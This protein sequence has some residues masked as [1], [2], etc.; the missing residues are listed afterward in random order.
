[1]HKLNCSCK[2][3]PKLQP[4]IVVI[5]HGEQIRCVAP[6]LLQDT[7]LN[8]QFSVLTLAPLPVRALKLC[9]G[10][11]IVSSEEEPASYYAAVFEF[12]WKN[13]SSFGLIFIENLD[14]RTPLWEFSH[15]NFV[16]GRRFRLFLASSEIDKAHQIILPA[17]HDAFMASLISKRRY[18]LRHYTRRL[19][20][21]HHAQLDRIT[22][23]QQVPAF[24]EHVDQVYRDCWQAEQNGYCSRNSRPQVRYFTAIAQ[25]GWLR[26]YI[27]HSDL[28]PLAYMLGYQYKGIYYF[29]ETG[30]ARTWSVGSPGTVLYHLLLE[31]LLR[32]DS[33]DLCDFISGDQSYK[34]SFSN[35]QHEVVSIYLAPPNRWRVILALQSAA[36]AV[37]RAVRQFLTA[38]RMDRAVRKLLRHN[39]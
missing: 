17:T 3:N 14:L 37:E 28:G 7:R 31:D 10:Q 21:E 23:V 24:L 39:T 19:I 13:R 18:T 38:L 20:K 15:A 1:L 9:G 27:L 36:F 26:S 4:M 33:P 2:R 16:R 35:T 22:D 5:R 34:K 11:F 29:Q 6:F 30:F 25:R 8:I 12:L 32:A